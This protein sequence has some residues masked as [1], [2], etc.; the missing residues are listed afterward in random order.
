MNM[1]SECE[2]PHRLNPYPLDAGLLSERT[3]SKL[4]CDM[5]R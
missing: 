3:G 1:I 4:V 5:T 2:V